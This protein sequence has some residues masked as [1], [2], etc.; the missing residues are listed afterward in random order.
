ARSRRVEI[1]D[2]ESGFRGVLRSAGGALDAESGGL[3]AC[4][5]RLARS[6]EQKPV[7]QTSVMSGNRADDIMAREHAGTCET[8]ECASSR[9]RDRIRIPGDC[10]VG[11]CPARGAAP[12]PDPPGPH[13]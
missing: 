5:G 6:E 7:A 13:V 1:W 2:V 3:L 8:D 4:R 9:G 10:R 12:T 11:V